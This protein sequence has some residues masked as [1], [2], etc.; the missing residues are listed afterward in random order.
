MIADRESIDPTSRIHPALAIL[1][2]PFS[3]V[4]DI[5]FLPYDA[6]HDCQSKSPSRAD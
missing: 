2:M 5:L 6:Y 4:G 1:D 3:F